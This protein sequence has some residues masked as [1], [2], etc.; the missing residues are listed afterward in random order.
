VK[1]VRITI[2]YT[3][4]WKALEE[5]L[6]ARCGVQLVPN[7]SDWP[8]YFTAEVPED[9]VVRVR[10]LIARCEDPD[11]TYDLPSGVV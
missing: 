5:L 1:K 4:R 7:D 9:R 3:P 10:E 8:D 2:R 11:S 6:V